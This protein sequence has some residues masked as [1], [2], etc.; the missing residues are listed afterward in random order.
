VRWKFADVIF[1]KKK[2]PGQI[3]RKTGISV[4]LAGSSRE[5]PELV[6]TG[7]YSFAALSVP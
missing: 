2:N 6:T 5:P 3:F 4:N 7:R 1:V